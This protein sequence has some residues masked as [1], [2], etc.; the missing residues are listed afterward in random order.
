LDR[1]VDLSAAACKARPQLVEYSTT[2]SP[3]GGG[4]K[5]RQ[6]VTDAVQ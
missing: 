3:A 4:A 5:L 1:P 6:Y 2:R